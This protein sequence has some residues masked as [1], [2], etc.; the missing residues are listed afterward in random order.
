MQPARVA[1]ASARDLLEGVL[2]AQGDAHVGRVGAR[3]GPGAERQGRLRREG[4]PYTQSAEG[5]RTFPGGASRCRGKDEPDTRRAGLPHTAGRQHEG[6]GHTPVGEGSAH[7][8]AE[9][10]AG[11]QRPGIPGRGPEREEGYPRLEGAGAAHWPAGGEHCREPDEGNS[12]THSEGA[13]Q[14]ACRPAPRPV[15]GPSFA[16]KRRTPERPQTRRA[17]RNRSVR[18]VGRYARMTGR[19]CFDSRRARRTFG[20]AP[21]CAVL[22]AEFGQDFFYAIMPS[23]TPP[24]KGR[25]SPSSR[26]AQHAPDH[27]LSTPVHNDGRARAR[28]C[29]FPHRE[30][31]RSPSSA[32]K[33]RRGVDRRGT[34]ALD[35]DP[36]AQHEDI[37]PGRDHAPTRRHRG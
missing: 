36:L 35:A 22:P 7:T 10:R 19:Y 11:C 6:H 17:Q 30:R 9:L 1:A 14:A 24:H 32:Q 18:L 8:A 2:E 37:H 3:A 31:E 23:P 4:T 5:P 12:R 26:R 28:A 29:L 16:H 34:L 27:S 15:S 25:A 20:E 13:E 21:A 33:L